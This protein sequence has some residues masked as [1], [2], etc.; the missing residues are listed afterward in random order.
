MTNEKPRPSE[1]DLFRAAFG[2]GSSSQREDPDAPS[3]KPE[4]QPPVDFGGGQRG[5]TPSKAPDMDDV[6]RAAARGQLRDR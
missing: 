2:L 5:K 1:A 6:L 3:A 4:E